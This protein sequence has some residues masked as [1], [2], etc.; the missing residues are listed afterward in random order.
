MKNNRNFYDFFFSDYLIAILTLKF[1]IS[2]MY[3]QYFE[4][5]ILLFFEIKKKSQKPQNKR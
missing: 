5:C 2:D 4:I 1:E 3:L